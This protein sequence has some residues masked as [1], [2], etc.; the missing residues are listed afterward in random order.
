LVVAAAASPSVWTAKLE[1]KDGSKITGTARVESGAS[2]AMPKRDSTMQPRDTTMPRDTTAS[3]RDT[4]KAQPSYSTTGMGDLRVT[5]S[6]NNAPQN[7][8]LTWSI[9][10]G[11]CHDASAEVKDVTSATGSIKVDA[12]GNGT[13]SSQVKATL[14]TTGDLHI[15]VNDGAKQAACGDLEPAKTSTEN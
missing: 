8:T 15:V 6:V 1:G 10:S 14:P 5:I 3:Y 7:S 13:A 4:T 12:S 9:R 11:E 2:A